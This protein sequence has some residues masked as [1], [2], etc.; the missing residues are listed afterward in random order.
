MSEDA[1][2]RVV[3]DGE[4]PGLVAV[5]RAA[6]R[7]AQRLD[8]ALAGVGL[9]DAVLFIVAYVNDA[10]EPVVRVALTA[11]GADRLAQQLA[12]DCG[13]PTRGGGVPPRYRRDDSGAA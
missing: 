7:G 13:G 3:G 1:V 6:A 8:S 11:A 5:Y 12:R 4:A 9:A 10:D 2:F